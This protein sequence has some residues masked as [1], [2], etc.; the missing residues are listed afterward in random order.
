MK[1]FGCRCGNTVFFENTKCVACDHEL[2][3]CP[4]CQNVTTLLPADGGRF[5]CGNDSCTSV[6]AK[7]H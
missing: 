1:T 5:H 3:W 2:G 7:C 4:A 6:L